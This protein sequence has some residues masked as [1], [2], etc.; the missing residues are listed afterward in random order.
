MLRTSNTLHVNVHTYFKKRV[1]ILLGKTLVSSRAEKT[2]LQNQQNSCEENKVKVWYVK[3]M[4]STNPIRRS[5][6]VL[7]FRDGKNNTTGLTLFNTTL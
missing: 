4:L 5:V 3:S 2:E 1:H 7:C 6:R